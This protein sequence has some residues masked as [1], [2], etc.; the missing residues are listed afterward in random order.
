[1]SIFSKNRN[2]VRRRVYLPKVGTAASVQVPAG[3][4]DVRIHA[5]NK[6]ATAVS[7]SAGNVTGGAQFAAVTA[8][9]TGTVSAPAVIALAQI[10][11]TF[12]YQADAQ[13][14]VTATVAGIADVVVSYTEL[15]NSLPL[16]KAG[17]YATGQQ[18]NS[19]Q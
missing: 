14:Y 4:T 17:S 10:N 6:T 19:A 9:G 16:M 11:A 7:V 13:V 5:Q 3:A 15:L 2:V 8:V 12:V 18:G 1:M